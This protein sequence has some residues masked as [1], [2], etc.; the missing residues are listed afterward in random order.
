MTLGQSVSKWLSAL[1]QQSGSLVAALAVLA[2][3]AVTTR[4]TGPI[5]LTFAIIAAA[6]TAKKYKQT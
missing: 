4:K 1:P 5:V 2:I 6:W 3:V